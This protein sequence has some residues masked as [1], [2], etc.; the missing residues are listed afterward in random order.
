MAATILTQ[1]SAKRCKA[2]FLKKLHPSAGTTPD[3]IDA[4]L[5][6]RIAENKVPVTI[7]GIFA[8]Y[9]ILIITYIFNV[10]FPI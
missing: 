5:M 9:P 2:I 10:H 4:R 7:C 1:C 8:S 3:F 6:A